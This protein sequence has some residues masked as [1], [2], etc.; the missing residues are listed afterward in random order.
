MPPA[1]I[2][3]ETDEQIQTYH[4][5]PDDWTSPGESWDEELVDPGCMVYIGQGQLQFLRINEV[6]PGTV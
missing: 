5:R 1:V 6:D 4:H 2:Y 3:L